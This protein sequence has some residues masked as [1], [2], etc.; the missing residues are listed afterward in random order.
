MASVSWRLTCLYYDCWWLPFSH[1][2]GAECKL[3]VHLIAPDKLNM[4][5]AWPPFLR[6]RPCLLLMRVAAQIP[7][8]LSLSSTCTVD[9]RPVSLLYNEVGCSCSF[10]SNYLLHPLSHALRCSRY[11]ISELAS[12]ISSSIR[13]GSSSLN[14]THLGNCLLYTSPSP[15]D[16]TLSRMP[17]SA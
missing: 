1:G 10:T 13:R 2:S 14:F 11:Y 5:V 7:L 9:F 15:R 16:A 6:S 4:H 12:F 17:S 3:Y 8:L